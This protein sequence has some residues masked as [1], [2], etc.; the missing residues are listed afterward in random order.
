MKIE[1]ITI[2]FFHSSASVPNQKKKK[3]KTKT[4]KKKKENYKQ[5]FLNLKCEKLYIYFIITSNSRDWFCKIRRFEVQNL[6]CK[7][8]VCSK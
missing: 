4:K 3:E 6:L 8:K 2:M 5:T 7:E 1:F